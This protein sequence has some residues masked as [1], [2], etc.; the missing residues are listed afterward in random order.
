MRNEEYRGAIRRELESHP[1]GWAWGELRDRLDLP[2]VR[3]C[4][5]WMGRLEQEAG[6]QRASGA[7]RAY[8]WTVPKRPRA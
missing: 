8:V 7:G 2:H 5:P 4:P 6:L 3:P 1:A